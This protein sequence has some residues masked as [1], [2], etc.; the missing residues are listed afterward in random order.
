MLDTWQSAAKKDVL[1]MRIKKGIMLL[2]LTTPGHSETKDR[3][4]CSSKQHV[5]QYRVPTRE[6]SVCDRQLLTLQLK[7]KRIS[8]FLEHN[9]TALTATVGCLRLVHVYLVMPRFT[10]RTTES[11]CKE[12]PGT[13]YCLTPTVTS[14]QESRYTHNLQRHHR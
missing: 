4:I 10:R 12:Q 2:I 13:A 3:R 5:P 11:S 7:F 9:S 8:V 6:H 1:C 14:L